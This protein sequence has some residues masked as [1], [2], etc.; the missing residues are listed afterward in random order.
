MHGFCM[1]R[2]SEH[3]DGEHVGTTVEPFEA[4]QAFCEHTYMFDVPVHELD[5]ASQLI[6]SNVL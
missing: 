4:V 1:L 6:D 5:E 3:Q 2:Y